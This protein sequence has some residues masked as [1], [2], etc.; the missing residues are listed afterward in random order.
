NR[1][2]FHTDVAEWAAQHGY[3]EVRADGKIHS[4]RDKLRLDRFREHDVEIVV[5]VL[6]AGSA[7]GSRAWRGG[8]PRKTFSAGRREEHA[9]GVRL[10]KTPQQLLAGALN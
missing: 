8:S 3:T 2:G 7:R 1:K 6:E 9:G 5:G 10:P 4:T